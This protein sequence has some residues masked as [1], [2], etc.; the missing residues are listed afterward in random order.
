MRPP[1]SRRRPVEEAEPQRPQA[2]LPRRDR[3]RRPDQRFEPRRD[4]ARP[5]ILIGA[6]DTITRCVR[7]DI[8]DFT[9]I[10]QGR[11]VTDIIIRDA[12]EMVGGDVHINFDPSQIHL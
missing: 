9:E 11:I 3:R 2:E 12:Q 10:S 1:T 6:G 8:T 5:P 4:A 7:R